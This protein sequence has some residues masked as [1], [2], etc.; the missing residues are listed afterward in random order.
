M[1]NANAAVKFGDKVSEVQ[2]LEHN[3]LATVDHFCGADLAV[4]WK[5]ENGDFKV[6]VQ[7]VQHWQKPHRYAPGGNGFRQGQK[8]RIL[9]PGFV[10]E[11]F[12]VGVVGSP[13]TGLRFLELQE[14]GWKGA[15]GQQPPQLAGRFSSRYHDPIMQHVVEMEL[16]DGAKRIV[17]SGL[18]EEQARQ[19][20]AR[21]NA[22]PVPR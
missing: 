8:I 11:V 21:K 20:A 5:P 6:G 3:Q 9:V 10:S 16:D 2:P 17:S 1:S 15:P 22:D 14:A 7:D 18:S 12:V 19:A 13:Q 4:V